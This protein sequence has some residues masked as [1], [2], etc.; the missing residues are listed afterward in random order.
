MIKYNW[1]YSCDYCDEKV[2]DSINFNYYDHQ[3]VIIPNNVPDA[4]KYG[5]WRIVDGLLVCPN[6]KV[7]IKDEDEEEE[8]E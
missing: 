6:H 4:T 1:T 5:R 3:P 8:N 7:T 2:F